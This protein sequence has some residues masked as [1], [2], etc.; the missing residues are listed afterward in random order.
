MTRLW[1]VC[2]K[3]EAEKAVAADSGTAHVQ[4]RQFYNTPIEI[5]A[6]DREGRGLKIRH[7]VQQQATEMAILTSNLS[8][9]TSAFAQIC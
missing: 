9:T 2:R 4:P 6:A 3:E 7:L 1:K 8:W 5:A